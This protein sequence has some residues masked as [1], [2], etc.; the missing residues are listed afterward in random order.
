MISG[1]YTPRYLLKN[2]LHTILSDHY[3]EFLKVYDKRYIEKYGPLRGVV[4]KTIQKILRCSNPEDGF[5]HLRCRG[6]GREYICPF[7]CK[8][9]VCPSCGQKRLLAWCEWLFEKVL[10]R[11]RHRHWCFTI[12][13]CIRPIFRKHRFLLGE[14]CS[15]AADTLTY[16]M[17]GLSGHAEASP[18]IV[19]TIQTAGDRANWNP[20]IH[21]IATVGVLAPDYRYYLVPKIPYDVMRIAWRDRVLRMLLSYGFISQN[22]A[23]K[24]KKRYPNGFMLN[25][26]IRDDWDSNKVISHLAEYIIRAP[27]AES[28][29]V[30]YNRDRA[31][32]TIEY[33]K[34][35][36]SGNKTKRMDRE[37]VNVLDFIAR[38]IQHIPEVYQQMVRYYGVYSNRSR[39]GRKT[40][41]VPEF[42]LVE[43]DEPSYGKSWRHL[44]WKIYEIDPLRCPECGGEL[45]LINIVSY[46]SCAN[47][48]NHPILLYIAVG[49]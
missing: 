4:K 48:D 15:L 30:E 6:C 10:F 14:L 5:A 19:A 31:E 12:P 9:R 13:V 27:V 36:A 21:L 22:Y 16:Y 26:K 28:R 32:V 18:G 39:G 40:E 24:L 35:D 37:T 33:R 7:S 29:I 46:L 41:E 42:M 38:F 34:R 45:E 23:T 20:H 44:I 2:K 47:M 3:D 8:E 43:D 1:L 17:R 25:G 49:I 11:L